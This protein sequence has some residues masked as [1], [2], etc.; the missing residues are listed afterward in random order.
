MVYLI[1]ATRPA[2]AERKRTRDRRFS[3]V[4]RAASEAARRENVGEPAGIRI[5][6]WLRAAKYIA[7]L[8]VCSGGRLRRRPGL[9]RRGA[10]ARRPIVASAVAALSIGSPAASSLAL[11]AL[12][13]QANRGAQRVLLAMGVR[14]ALPLVAVVYFT[15]LE[16]PAGRAGGGRVD[17]RALPCRPGRRDVVERA[18]CRSTPAAGGLRGRDAHGVPVVEAIPRQSRR[19]SRRLDMTRWLP[20]FSTSRTRTTSRCRAPCGSRIASRSATFPSTTCGSIRT[21]RIGKPI[22]STTASP[23]ST[24]L[25]GCAGRRSR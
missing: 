10:M 23:R 11:V 9:W 18:A 8:G 13:K 2:E 5:T 16:S 4:T 1:A 12:A 25:T 20:P 21:T 15:Q 7:V 24:A 6:T 3:D 22:G 19:Y 17:R 14:M